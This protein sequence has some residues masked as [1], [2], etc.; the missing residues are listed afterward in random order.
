MDIARSIAHFI[1]ELQPT[2]RLP[3]SYNPNTQTAGQG[4]T[5]FTG[6]WHF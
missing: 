5:I 4:C 2:I 6:L 1:A 3:Y